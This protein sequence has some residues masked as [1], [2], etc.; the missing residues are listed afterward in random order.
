[1]NA[2]KAAALIAI[3][4]DA[5][6]LDKGLGDARK[7]LRSFG[8]DAKKIGGKFFGA[9]KGALKSIGAGLGLQAAL[10]ITGA[11]DSFRDFEK[12]LVRFQVTSGKSTSA[13]HAFRGS[14]M[15]ISKET[16]IAHD[17][18]LGGASAYV[19]LTGDV[20]GAERAMESFAR[21]AQASGSSTAEV[22][23]AAAALR[24]SF[25]IDPAD[26]EKAFSSLISQ[27]K[28][29]AVELKDLASELSSVAPLFAQFGSMGGLG[30]VGQL[31]AALQVARKNFG[32]ASEAA[33]GLRGMMVALQANAKRFEKAGIRVF[34]KDAKTGAKTMR[35]FSDIWH[36]ISNSKLVNDPTLLTEAFGREEA[37]RA[38]DALSKHS[39][40]YDELIAAGQ[41][42]G[43]VTEDFGTVMA[44]DAFKLEK[45]I[46]GV[47]V[48]LAEA[49]TPERIQ[50]F[51]AF[52]QKLAD[53]LGVVIDGFGKLVDF[54]TGPDL[55][56]PFLQGYG[57]EGHQSNADVRGA[58]EGTLA[59]AGS[60]LDMDIDSKIAYLNK[61]R[62]D[63]ARANAY[64]E[65]SGAIAGSG[66]SDESLRRAI[67]AKYV[68]GAVNSNAGSAAAGEQYLRNN[69]V[70][71]ER[72]KAMAE[73]VAAQYEA[74][75]NLMFSKLG[76][77]IKQAMETANLN[78]NLDNNKV[79]RAQ[80]NAGR[81]RG[82]G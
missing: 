81:H 70:S 44:S 41:N 58:L 18:I 80:D 6:G 20:A 62:E 46:N 30:G 34:N 38:F 73:H 36:D 72:E 32:S 35:N 76:P 49:F 1:M 19:A 51:V 21:I 28:A 16:A 61:I 77:V 63:L 8:T 31:G 64:D 55:D 40:L 66:T 7:K 48:A 69:N 47:K 25:A 5:K 50:K 9:G 42:Y 59:N 68:G 29:G 60:E 27:G 26:F 13:M 23:T 79:S 12:Q 10:G 65:S 56:N 37:K 22:A 3:K 2:K 78:V 75:A 17:E 45:A 71:P 43:A 54:V 52:M 74:A 82:G 4:A 11:M 67:E 39:G 57:A 14:I 33:N 53:K 15:R 24:D